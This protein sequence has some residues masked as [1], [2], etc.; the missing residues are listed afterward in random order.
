M[1]MSVCQYNFKGYQMCI[2]FDKKPRQ[3]V[4]DQSR[5]RA[6]HGIHILAETPAG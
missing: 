3:S 1:F 6:E 5:V 2:I 4:D